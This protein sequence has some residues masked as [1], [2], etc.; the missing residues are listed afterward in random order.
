MKSVLREAVERIDA[1]RDKMDPV[2]KASLHNDLFFGTMTLRA[3]LAKFEEMEEK[4][5]RFD[6]DQA[7]VE[8]RDTES[9]ELVELRARI[10]MLEV[11]L[12]IYEP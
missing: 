2:I 9:A 7:G 10:R 4:S 12:E 5:M 11:M 1:A 3:Y 8:Q 6:L